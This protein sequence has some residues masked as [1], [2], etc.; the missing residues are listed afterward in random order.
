MSAYAMYC[1]TFRLNG[2]MTPDLFVSTP[3]YPDEEAKREEEDSDD[4]DGAGVE[5][6]RGD[7]DGPS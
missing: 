1:T 6:E 4:C 7:G 2:S 3:R 5:E